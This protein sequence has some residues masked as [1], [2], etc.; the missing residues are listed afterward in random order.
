[1]FQKT[2]IA[3][4]FA[5]LSLNMAGK[6][7]GAQQ[8]NKQHNKGANK[9][10]AIHA[11]IQAGAKEGEVVPTIDELA[12][13]EA[14]IIDNA[15]AERKSIWLTV[16]KVYGADMP[17]LE[18]YP[19]KV[20]HAYAKRLGLNLS[21]TRSKW[22]ASERKLYDSFVA[23]Q[24]SPL[25]LMVNLAKTTNAHRVVVLLEGPGKLP[26]KVTQARIELGLPPRTRGTKNVND[27]HGTAAAASNGNN[28]SGAVTAAERKTS[29]KW[30][31]T[32]LKKKRAVEACVLL[33]S[34][35]AMTSTDCVTI[36]QAATRRLE[37]SGDAF[38]KILG[39]MCKAGLEVFDAN[40]NRE[41]G[42]EE[43]DAA[44]DQQ[45]AKNAVG[46]N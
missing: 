10:V 18:S 2:L 43:Q 21:V 28:F 14:A 37:T 44:Q 12:E 34:S 38:E 29:D 27:N 40:I 30:D 26:E 13:R 3:Q 31:L 8:D 46:Q 16:F 36:I 39:Q 5:F 6:G 20:R 45:D 25:T 42:N 11:A 17:I 15:T 9:N 7:G 33:I 23:N 32:D 41:D 35:N 22:E 4:A 1:M 19:Q 24:V